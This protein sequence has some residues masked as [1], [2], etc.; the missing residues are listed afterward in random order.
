MDEATQ[1][2]SAASRLDLIAARIRRYQVQLKKRWWILL[3]CASVAVCWQA[4][5]VSNEPIQW[6]SYA[7][8]VAGGRIN[9]QNNSGYR[10]SG[11]DDFY[12]T[13]MELIRSGEVRKRVFDRLQALNPDLEPSPVTLEVTRTRDSSIINLY[14][15]GDDADYVR[16][17]LNA[18]LDE[19]MNFR[20]EMKGQMTDNTLNAITEE[21]LRLERELK[22]MDQELADFLEI[23]PKILLEE[24]HNTAAEWLSRLNSEKEGLVKVYKMYDQLDLD[25]SIAQRQSL[26][27]A[28]AEKEDAPNFDLAALALGGEERE[29]VTAKM[30]IKIAENELDSMMATFKS[31]HPSITQKKGEIERL[32]LRVDL[33]RQQ[34]LENIQK[35]KES[36]K[37]QIS[38]LEN[39]ITEWDEKAID[40]AK[41]IAEHKSIVTR[42]ARTRSL[43]D[44]LLRSLRDLDLSRSL[45]IDNLSI[46]E[47]A[48]PAYRQDPDPIR[49]LLSG[50]GLGLFVGMGILFL[51]DRLDDRMNTVSEFQTHF[52]EDVLGQV[53]KQSEKDGSPI[54]Q[55]DDERHL[56]VEAYRNLRS[57]I[58]FKHWGTHP[59]KL[60]LV[61]SALPSEGKTTTSAN[62]AFTMATAGAQV[63]LIDGDLR[64]GE[65]NEAFELEKSP[66]FGEILTER[67]AWHETVRRTS[68][69]N[70]YFIPRGEP[71]PQTSEYLLSSVTPPFLEEV[72]S[73]FD[74]VIIDSAPVMAADDTTSLAPKV[75][76]TLFVVRLSATPARIVAQ[77]LDQLYDRQVSVGGVV[78]NQTT[79]SLRDYNY[80]N[81]YGYYH[82]TDY[83]YSKPT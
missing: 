68:T 79:T 11:G 77:A 36:L 34:S 50:F 46:M 6:V 54:L 10:E 40:L 39:N 58:L 24:G 17:Y 74:Y 72:R 65:L 53:P 16:A 69:E 38:N 7:R 82:Y 67:A 63:L 81:Y 60:I 21:L 61:T 13:Q 43:Y 14:C 31:N 59:P 76:T 9:V 27:Q 49:P 45:D 56:F 55:P 2:Q 64:R 4:W 25:E 44:G 51:V 23:N 15:T 48:K 3:L 83:Y 29:Y 42:T 66:G 57:S 80:Y 28:V 30:N 78:L 19:F 33:H 20:R 8:I 1:Q 26:A 22:T 35:R 12:G 62:L 47:R 41:K 5:K 73:R 52:T 18:V 71:L 75:D 70:L 32:N 37:F